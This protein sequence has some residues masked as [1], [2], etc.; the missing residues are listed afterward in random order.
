[1][2]ILL[3]RLLLTLALVGPSMIPDDRQPLCPAVSTL[4]LREAPATCLQAGVQARM[5]HLQRTLQR[6]REQVQHLPPRSGQ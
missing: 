3:E 2:K 1:M 5:E 6:L 4:V